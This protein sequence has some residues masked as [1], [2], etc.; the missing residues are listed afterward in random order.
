MSHYFTP[1]EEKLIRVIEDL[2][3]QLDAIKQ[4][5]VYVQNHT[6]EKHCLDHLK[7]VIDN[8][9]SGTFDVLKL[10]QHVYGTPPKLPK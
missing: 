3:K 5:R 10:Y 2:H 6:N 8:Q 4:A 9:T 7:L 1:N